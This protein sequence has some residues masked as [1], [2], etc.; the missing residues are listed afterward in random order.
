MS[1][2]VQ[3]IEVYVLTIPRSYETFE[4]VHNWLHGFGIDEDRVSVSQGLG[5]VEFNA[6]VEEAEDLL[7]TKYH[8]YEHT[9]S[10]HSHI[11]CEEYSVPEHL[12]EHVDI[13]LPTVHF[14]TNAHESADED[15]LAKRNLF[16][17]EE[18]PL[19]T[20][21]K[22]K[23][24]SDR[25]ASEPGPDLKLCSQ[26]I[27]PGCIRALYGIPENDHANKKNS[28]GIVGFANYVIHTFLAQTKTV[29]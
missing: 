24:S 10:G 29:Y 23:R 12:S 14:D 6:T 13:I 27:T 21:A 19:R 20:S 7:K 18:D 2:P 28:F 25:R 1:L 22:N 15:L 5:W 4:A 8:L 3:C 17:L 16:E 26:R 11:A 9:S